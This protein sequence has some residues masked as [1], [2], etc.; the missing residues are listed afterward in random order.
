MTSNRDLCTSYSLY[1]FSFQLGTCQ[2]IQYY[3]KTNKFHT[4]K[5][6]VEKFILNFMNNQKN[7]TNEE[8]ATRGR[9]ERDKVIKETDK[10]V[11]FQFSLKKSTITKIRL[12]KKKPDIPELDKNVEEYIKLIVPSREE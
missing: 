8:S 10:Y 1:S 11:S 4:L 5:Q 12:Y 3:R 2:D 9:P 7:P 6:D